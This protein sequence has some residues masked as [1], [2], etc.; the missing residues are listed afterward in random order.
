[1]LFGNIYQF[2]DNEL[3][4]EKDQLRQKLTCAMK[5]LVISNIFH[6]MKQTLRS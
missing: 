1:M 5:V 3:T 6:D 4:Y 2:R